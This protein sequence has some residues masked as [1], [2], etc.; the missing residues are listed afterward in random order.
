MQKAANTLTRKLGPLPVYAYGLLAVAVW[1]LFLRGGVT[2]GSASTGLPY[3]PTSGSAAQQ[4]ASGQGTPADN[5]S[6]D[7]LSALLGNQSSSYDALLA[8]LQYGGGAGGGG[9]GGGVPGGAGGGTSGASATPGSDTSAV[10]APTIESGASSS[11]VASFAADSPASAAPVPVTGALAT[12]LG[13]SPSAGL[14]MDPATGQVYGPPTTREGGQRERVGQPYQGDA[15]SRYLINAIGYD[16]YVSSAN[17]MTTQTPYATVAPSPV[18][19][20]SAT[21]ADPTA[22]RGKAIA[23]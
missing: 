10:T 19:T 3:T 20:T 16:P 6:S 7:L 11:P 8:A 9:I 15:V 1:F 22:I 23:S 4:P 12:R 18:D 17:P 5:A 2:A 21:V 14:T 13:Y